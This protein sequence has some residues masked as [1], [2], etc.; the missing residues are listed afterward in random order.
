MAVVADERSTD[1]DTV[2]STDL[3]ALG[4]VVDRSALSR[5]RRRMV[6]AVVVLFTV[7]VLF[8]RFLRPSVGESGPPR[9]EVNGIRVELLGDHGDGVDMDGSGYQ[10]AYVPGGEVIVDLTFYGHGTMRITEFEYVPPHLEFP[11]LFE[12][13]AVQMAT[14]DATV[15]EDL[16]FV[17]FRPFELRAGSSMTVRTTL[18][19]ANCG[20]KPAGMGVYT[21]PVVVAEGAG[22]QVVNLPANVSVLSPPD[23]LCPERG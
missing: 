22:R 6:L 23:S 14:G 12:E 21:N 9:F 19:F 13:V 1:P 2:R 3:P 18:R 10:V 4:P 11:A 7:G 20:A 15:D 17:P 8:V 16:E 5:R